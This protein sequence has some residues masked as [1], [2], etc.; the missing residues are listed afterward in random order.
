M[1]PELTERAA[2]AGATITQDKSAAITVAGLRKSYGSVQ[3]VRD[4]SFCVRSGEIVALLGPN[5]AGKTT[6][7]EILEGFRA[8]DGG[9]VAVL[10]LDPG[11][12]AAA[13]RTARADRAGPAGHRGRALPDGARDHRPP[14]R[15][16]PGPQGRA[17]GHQPRR[18]RRAGAAQGQVPVRR[19]EAPP[20]PRP[21][22][23]RRPGTAVPGRADDRV[24][25]CRAPR[26][27]GPGPGA[28]RGRDH[29]PADH[30]RHGRGTGARRP[31]GAA[32]QRCRGGRGAAGRSR[33]ARYG[34]GTHHLHAAARLSGRRPSGTCRHT[35]RCGGDRD[36][37]P[38]RG[39]APA[40]Q[41]GPAS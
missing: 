28:A 32:Q 9:A 14:G 26:C 34:T 20:G 17:R 29:D 5:G 23:D 38:D 30:T 1:H 7:L 24:R 18:P 40:D 33:R 15:L 6:T 16:L 27:L 41:L 35:K 11:D 25:P 36:R 37:Q 2:P 19:P 13:A 3:A 8:R 10:G 31:G 21:R 4:V 12:K 22:P 39:I